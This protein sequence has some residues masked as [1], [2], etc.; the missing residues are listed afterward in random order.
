MLVAVWI[1]K[2]NKTN[3]QACKAHS[4]FKI[5][6]IPNVHYVIAYTEM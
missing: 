6:V 2:Q 1:Q 4:L 5:L 3:K